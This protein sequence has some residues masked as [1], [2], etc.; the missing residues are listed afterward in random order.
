MGFSYIREELVGDA[1]FSLENSILVE[2]LI[3]VRIDDVFLSADHTYGLVQVSVIYIDFA[4]DKVI[5]FGIGTGCHG[6]DGS[7]DRGVSRLSSHLILIFSVIAFR[8]IIFDGS[9]DI[10]EREIVLSDRSDL[11]HRILRNLHFRI[12]SETHIQFSIL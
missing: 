7:S 11:H 8:E 6:Q 3:L 9:G 4:T 1:S 10:L 5:G 12:A 2:L